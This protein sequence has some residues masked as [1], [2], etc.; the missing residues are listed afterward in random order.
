MVCMARDVA[1]IIASHAHWAC[2]MHFFYFNHDVCTQSIN[3]ACGGMFFSKR[4]INTRW[5]MSYPQCLETTIQAHTMAEDKAVSDFVKEKFYEYITE[6]SIIDR[7]GPEENTTP[8][9][10]LALPNTVLFRF[11]ELLPDHLRCLFAQLCRDLRLFMMRFRRRLF[12][13]PNSLQELDFIRHLTLLS[14]DSPNKWAC[15]SCRTLHENSPMDV[16]GKEEQAGCFSSDYYF[17]WQDE[18]YYRIQR[19]HVVMALKYA[20][21][22][23]LT[24]V[25]MDHLLELLASHHTTLWRDIWSVSLHP[26]IRRGRFLLEIEIYSS[27]DAPY[28]FSCWPTMPSQLVCGHQMP[29]VAAEHTDQ[30]PVCMT[31]FSV[32]L[33]IGMVNG[34]SLHQ[35]SVCA[36]KFG[37]ER[38]EKEVVVSVWKDL[39]PETSEE[40]D[41]SLYGIDL[42]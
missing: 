9:P 16:P 29:P 18:I 38:T 34:R 5:H 11:L 41:F 22:P 33:G 42:G 26:T 20:R 32:V 12:I 31:L 28:R 23:T 10:L 30:H 24:E 7:M 27:V 39:G 25:Q 40:H 36:T 35:C 13:L 19:H 6:Y 14:R 21:Q 1:L 8:F 17:P 2:A 37:V 15:D 3:T 4:H